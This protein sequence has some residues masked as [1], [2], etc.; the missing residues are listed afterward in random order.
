MTAEDG[1]ARALLA[2]WCREAAWR[3]MST[4]RGNMFAVRAGSDPARLPVGSGSHLDTQPH[5]G[6]FD[7]I[8]G[9]LAAL[10]VAETLNDAG[11]QTAAPIAVI[12]WTNEEGVRYAPGLMG[13]AWYSGLLDDAR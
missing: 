8:S 12:N 9:V 7:G 6:R 13:S 11:I 4:V 5:G 3:C 10:E 2:R 1:E